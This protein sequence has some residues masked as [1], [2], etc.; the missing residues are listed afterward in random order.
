MLPAIARTADVQQRT[1]ALIEAVYVHISTTRVLISPMFSLGL[2]VWLGN[3][4]EGSDNPS[5]TLDALATDSRA[6]SNKNILIMEPIPVPPILASGD[7][8]TATTSEEIR[9]SKHTYQ[10]SRKIDRAQQVLCMQ[11]NGEVASV[12]NCFIQF[13]VLL[14]Y[15]QG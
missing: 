12:V 15:G 13:R 11:V 8:V 14:S 10:A 3:V 9:T 4:S 5:Q 7:L 2:I 6:Y 1:S